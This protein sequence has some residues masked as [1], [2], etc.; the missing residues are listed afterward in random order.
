M[1]AS[2]FDVHSVIF[3]SMESSSSFSR[4]RI[5]LKRSVLIVL[6]PFSSLFPTKSFITLLIKFE[7]ILLGILT[8]RIR[9][10]AKN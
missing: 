5:V 6:L 10:I 8:L 4:V 3:S 9:F 7:I 2:I 1:A